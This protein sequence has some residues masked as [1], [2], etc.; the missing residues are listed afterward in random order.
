[1]KDDNS[2]LI[3]YGPCRD[4]K[5]IKSLYDF[6]CAKKNPIGYTTLCK[7]CANLYNQKRRKDDPAYKTDHNKWKS[8]YRKT[9]AGRKSYEKQ[10]QRRKENPHSEKMRDLLWKTL[11]RKGSKKSSRS[12]IMLGYTSKQFKEKF[13]VINKGY[14]IDHK[15]PVS[16]FKNETPAF[17]I[18]HL[19]NLQLL[20]AG[21]NCSKADHYADSISQAFLQECLPWIKENYINLIPING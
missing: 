2:V 14:H 21:I 18:D 9:I 15:I 6:A 20:P 16:W 17:I 10:Y 4:C 19:E 13:P 12:E 1:M 5:Q 8:A 11:K 7:M 3:L